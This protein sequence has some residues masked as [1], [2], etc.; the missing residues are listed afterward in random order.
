MHNRFDLDNEIT[1]HLSEV[2]L[3]DN[4]R[5]VVVD[6]DGMERISTVIE[7]LQEEDDEETIIDEP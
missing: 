2:D 1:P 6:N 4:N 7:Q 5:I 3:D